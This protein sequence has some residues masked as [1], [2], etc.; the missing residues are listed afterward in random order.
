MQTAA[1]VAVDCN[2]VLV[3]RELTSSLCP[4][5]L[6]P[7]VQRCALSGEGD[8]VAVVVVDGSCSGTWGSLSFD[9]IWTRSKNGFIFFGLPFFSVSLPVLIAGVSVSGTMPNR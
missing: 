9:C 1:A 5:S 7:L 8:V 2:C 6:L 3:W 4:P